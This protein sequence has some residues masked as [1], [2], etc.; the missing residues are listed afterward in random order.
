MDHVAWVVAPLVLVCVLAFSAVAKLGQGATLRTII[1]NLRLPPWVLPQ[2][3]ARAVPGLEL[4]LTVG[5]LAPWVPVFVVAAAASLV[6]MSAYWALIARGLTITPRPSCGCFG[7]AGDHRISGRTLVRNTL[8]VAAAGAA[9]T[10]A[11]SG[12][13]VWTLLSAGS[14]G[15]WLWLGLAALACLVTG[16]VLGGAPGPATPAPW[17]VPPPQEQESRDEPVD[18]GSD[19]DD[20]VR[21]VTPHLV[22]HEPGVGPATLVELSAARAQLLVL[23]NCYCVSTLELLGRVEAWDARLSVVDVRLVLSVAVNDGL[24]PYP[25]GTLV[26]HGGLVWAGLGLTVSPSAVLL[27]ADG[28]L[29]GGPVSG[30]QAVAAFVDDIEETL[31]QAP[32]MAQD[33]LPNDQT[34]A[35]QDVADAAPD[36]QLTGDR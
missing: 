16:L 26:D 31:R 32:T 30:S 35:P 12:R 18:E 25:R 10:I 7:Q 20:Y 8:L 21:A 6:L 14:V 29:A 28:F 2:P 36:R 34:G 19:A 3:F 11:L 33:A 1:R 4:A 23:V 13:T 27:G 22:L 5:L 9:L 24:A 17:P 15:D